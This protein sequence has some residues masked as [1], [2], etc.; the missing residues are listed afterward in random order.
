MC[1]VRRFILVLMFSPTHFWGREQHRE[2]L[3][4]PTAGEA[5]QPGPRGKPFPV[6]LQALGRLHD[7]GGLNSV[8]PPTPHS[9][10]SVPM[11]FLA[12]L[13]WR[14][15]S[16]GWY[17]RL[18][19]CCTCFTCLVKVW[20]LESCALTWQRYFSLLRTTVVCWA[21]AAGALVGASGGRLSLVAVPA[22]NRSHSRKRV[23]GLPQR[24]CGVRASRGM[25][26]SWALVAPPPSSQVVGEDTQW[27]PFM[28]NP[29]S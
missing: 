6:E 22:Q 12:F 10:R 7:A 18:A 26:S 27:P 11:I 29:A 8:V 25:P 3:R 23:I 14:R 4:S 15:L 17:P 20:P 13:T 21:A 19:S 28:W 2:C 1:L 5:L 9:Y 16:S 24:D